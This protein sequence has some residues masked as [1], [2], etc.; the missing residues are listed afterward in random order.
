MA[1]TDRFADM[2][3]ETKETEI[4]PKTIPPV[5]ERTGHL[6]ELYRRLQSEGGWKLDDRNYVTNFRI[7]INAS[8]GEP[9]T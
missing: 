2:I 6:W 4:F 5:N 3:G 8:E 9:N 7:D 1:W